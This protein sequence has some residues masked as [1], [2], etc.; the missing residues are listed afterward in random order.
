MKFRSFFPGPLFKGS[1]RSHLILIVLVAIIPVLLFSAVMLSIFARQE[2]ES[3]KAGLGETNRAL[4]SAL[5]LE[6]ES[7]LSTLVVL[8]SAASLDTGDLATFRRVLERAAPTRPDWKTIKLHDPA[9]NELIDLLSSPR[10][11]DSA[12]LR[13]SGFDE[14]LRTQKPTP[15]E[16]YMEPGIGPMVG[17]RAPVVRGG[18]IKYVLTAGIEPALFRNILARQKLPEG[19]VGVVFD[20]NGTIVAASRPELVGRSAGSLLKGNQPGEVLEGWVEGLNWENVPSYATFEKSP[21]SGWSVALLVPSETVQATLRQSLFAVAGAGALF[22]LGGLLLAIVIEERISTPLANLTM[23][24]NALGRGESVS[25]AG[26]SPVTEISALAQD[27]ERA[28]RLLQERAQERDRAEAETRQINQDLERLVIDQTRELATANRELETNIAELRD[29]VR[30]RHRIEDALRRE[31][32]HLELLQR[33]EL[34]TNEAGGIEAILSSAV[35]HICI[36]LKWHVGRVAY[37]GERF[38]QGVS[39]PSSWHIN[40]HAQ[41]LEPLRA[42]IDA[43]P[44]PGTLASRAETSQRV[45]LIGDLRQERGCEWARTALD[46]GLLSAVALP[47]LAANQVIA[48]LEFYCDHFVVF[49]DRLSS[50]ITRIADQLGRTVER[51]QAE[52]ALRLSEE[53]FRKAF[54]EGP[55]GIS[56][57]DANCRYFR[58]NRAFVE[59]LE[60]MEKDLLGQDCFARVHPLDAAKTR[61]LTERLLNGD[62]DN[63]RQEARYINTKG[64]PVWTHLTATTITSSDG[65]HK[66]ALQM[67][68]NITEQKRIEEKLRESERLAVLGATTAMFAHEIGNPLNSISTTVQLL[69]RDLTRPQP[70]GKEPMLA[71]LHDIRQEITRLGALLHE[72]RFLSR[73]QNLDLRPAPMDRLARELIEGEA[74]RYAQRGVKVE[75]AFAAELPLV[76]VDEERIKQALWNVCEN[77]VDA[78]PNGGTLNLRGY[79]YGDDVCLDIEDSGVGIPEGLDVFELFTT[80]KANGTGLGLAIARQIL[81]AHGGWIRYETKAGEGTVF[82]VALPQA[83]K[84]SAEER[85][86]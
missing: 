15:V 61:H 59:M 48:V 82:V 58:V 51:K 17:A 63:F 86:L 12:P 81:S 2:R 43:L 78:M 52:E 54:D 66:Y 79:P 74:E 40:G 24:A 13:D 69:E 50:I 1:L 14:L 55:I 47:V 53:R 19:S 33:T 3:V 34:A 28:A 46:C 26:A 31:H 20:R 84:S 32:H 49:D 83:L 8:A 10:P 36:H 65:S 68:E 71:S 76:L 22:L 73:P 23:A 85:Q 29:E 18:K 37:R 38:P 70:S 44:Y 39:A 35:E 56:L 64:E 62:I 80:T 21:T 5:E 72:F 30:E 4:A 77:A 25:F 67:V 6:F 45:E 41:R 11:D 75:A 16:Y 27:L 7:T 57:A 60:C 9:G 42:L